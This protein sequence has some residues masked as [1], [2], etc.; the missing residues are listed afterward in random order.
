[1]KQ[2]ILFMLLI[3]FGSAAISQTLSTDHSESIL[4]NG[5][6]INKKA[7]SDPFSDN[8]KTMLT[9]Y[10]VIHDGS[11]YICYTGIWPRGRTIDKMIEGVTLKCA[12]TD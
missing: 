8:P 1:M 11:F 12:G 6:I 9:I 10:E 3:I 7:A 5:R 4:V 2:A